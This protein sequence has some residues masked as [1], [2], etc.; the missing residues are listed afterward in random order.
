MHPGGMR[1]AMDLFVFEK[2]ANLKHP[3][4]HTITSSHMTLKKSKRKIMVTVRQKG[5]SSLARSTLGTGVSAQNCSMVVSGTST[6]GCRAPLHGGMEDSVA[7][8]GHSG[9]S[10]S[11]RL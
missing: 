4:I 11:M 1:S 9:A 3:N 7:C 6:W 10:A 5:K 8:H 2:S